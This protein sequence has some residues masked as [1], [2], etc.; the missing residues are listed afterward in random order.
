MAQRRAPGEGCIVKRGDG[1]YQVSLQVGGKRRTLY[2]T[3]RVEA[4]KKLL[5]LRQLALS[6]RIPDYSKRTVADLLCAWLDTVSTQLKPR[7]ISDYKQLV[8]KHVIPNIGSVRLSRLEPVHIQA[9]Y[10]ALLKQNKCRTAQKIHMLLHRALKLAV[11]W[12][13]LVENPCGRVLRPKY[14]PQARELWTQEELTLFLNR[15]KEHWLY[16]LFVAAIATGA[17]IGELLALQW[18][19]VDFRACVIS[20]AKAGQYIDGRW[21]V[22]EPKTRASVRTLTL[23]TA[24]VS[25]LHTQKSQQ[26]QLKLRAGQRWQEHGLVFT[27]RCGAPLRSTDV[28]NAFRKLCQKLQLRRIRIHDLR[29][30]HASLLLMEGLSLPDVS[31]RLGHASVNVTATIYAHA[32]DRCDERAAVAIGRVLAGVGHK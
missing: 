12:G 22:T 27:Q 18:S 2:A 20:I 8:E 19:D 16:P 1:R 11:M 3:S 26:L 29:H 4:E 23:P 17:R 15:A 14:R 21:V 32:I 5:A 7:T 25:A 13:W 6:G 31:K 24:A 30:L 10:S 9:L 28:A